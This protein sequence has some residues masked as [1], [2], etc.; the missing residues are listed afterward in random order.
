MSA[1][2]LASRLTRKIDAHSAGERSC[3]REERAESNNE[4]QKDHP[5]FKRNGD[6]IVVEHNLSLTE[7][8]C[9][10]HSVFTHLN[11]RQLLITSNPGE[12]VKPDVLIP[13]KN[14]KFC[15]LLRH[16]RSISS[17]LH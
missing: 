12:L 2:E 7:A 6:D 4:A 8:L 14:E 1:R 3:S 10:F 11:G 13:K 9:G 5:K 16:Q 15:L 17:A